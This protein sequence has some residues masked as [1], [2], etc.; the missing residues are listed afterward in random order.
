[1]L[2]AL[3]PL[4]LALASIVRSDGGHALFRQVRV[5]KNRKLFTCYKFRSM[6][7]NAEDVLKFYLKEHPKAAKEWITFQKL[8]NDIRITKFGNFIRRTSLDELPQLW[9]VLKGDMSF[10]G[11]RPCTPEQANLHAS[12]FALHQSVRPG[13]TGPWQVGGGAAVYHSMSV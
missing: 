2:I 13:I 11:P 12:G 6:R 1:M 10:V 9:N 4:F 8:K 3:L 7:V 5:G